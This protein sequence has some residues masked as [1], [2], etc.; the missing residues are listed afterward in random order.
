MLGAQK[1]FMA[2]IHSKKYTKICIVF[3]LTLFYG[4]ESEMR[5]EKGNLPYYLKICQVEYV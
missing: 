2:K 4:F 5:N 3:S 1:L